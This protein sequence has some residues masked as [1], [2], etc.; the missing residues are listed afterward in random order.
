M[1]DSGIGDDPF[2]VGLVLCEWVE[3]QPSSTLARVPADNLEWRRLVLDCQLSGVHL[4]EWLDGQPVVSTRDFTDEYLSYRLRAHRLLHTP[5]TS[6]R[7]RRSYP[8]WWVSS[9]SLRPRTSSERLPD[10]CLY[11]ISR[12][13]GCWL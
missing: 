1:R 9:T 5:S 3:G 6:V 7:S 13:P 4:G 12:H 8:R 2:H 11:L 10:N